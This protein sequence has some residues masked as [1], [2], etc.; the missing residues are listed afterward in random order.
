MA[1]RPEH[2]ALH[3]N[4]RRVDRTADGKTVGHTEP[5]VKPARK[6]ALKL[7]KHRS[8]PTTPPA[9]AV[10][11][12]KPVRATPPAGVNL[13]GC[14]KPSSHQG[15]CSVRWAKRRENHGPSGERPRVVAQAA[16]R[17]DLEARVAKLERRLAALTRGLSKLHTELVTD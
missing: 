6:N 13:C 5:Y 7:P 15:M 12:A 9:A 3:S 16:P 8:T 14:G 17:P 2:V 10:I 11:T 4:T 1:M